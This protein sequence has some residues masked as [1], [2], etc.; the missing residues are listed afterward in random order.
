V[1]LNQV[2]QT[3]TVACVL[4]I[5]TIYYDNDQDINNLILET[6]QNCRCQRENFTEISG[7]K[8]HKNMQVKL[9]TFLI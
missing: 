7:P 8:L 5:I 6:M 1:I 9:L 4:H 2:Q 3:V